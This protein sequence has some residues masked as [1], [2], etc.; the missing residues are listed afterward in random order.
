MRSIFDG[1]YRLIWNRNTDIPWMQMSGY[2]KSEYPA[3]TLFYHLYETGE[4]QTPL[5]NF[6]ASEKPEFELF[7]TKADPMEFNNLANDENFATIKNKLQETLTENLKEFDKNK[8]PEN[9]E[10]MQKAIKSSRNYY[11]SKVKTMNLAEEASNEEFIKYWE[12]KLL[13][14]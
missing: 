10:T 12:N 4:L 1:R 11:K 5:S 14:K 6:M 9:E 13:T 3:Y 2:K 8:I 7:D